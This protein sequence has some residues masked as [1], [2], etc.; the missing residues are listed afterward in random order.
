MPRKLNPIKGLLALVVL[1]WGPKSAPASSML[2]LAGSAASGGASWCQQMPLNPDVGCGMHR[3]PGSREIF[4]IDPIVRELKPSIDM[5]LTECSAVFD[6]AM[7]VWRSIAP[8]AMPR[9]TATASSRSGQGA[10]GRFLICWLPFG[11][12]QELAIRDEQ[13]RGPWLAYT[14]V[15]TR[16]TLGCGAI[17][18]TFI[19]FAANVTELRPQPGK[20][21][22]RPSGGYR[23]V[24]PRAGRLNDGEID[25]FAF[26]MHEY[27]HALGFDHVAWNNC[28]MNRQV[29][30]RG[31]THHTI[32]ELEQKCIAEWYRPKTK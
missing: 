19:C 29:D 27:G 13:G 4:Q 24:K 32:P 3:A 1:F 21:V 26:A 14:Y 30:V 31:R 7:K 5:N 16:D 2:E 23:W 25:F 15:S 20:M 11:E 8:N 10:S 28:I 9:D 18:S 17:D 6:S 22:A 12:V